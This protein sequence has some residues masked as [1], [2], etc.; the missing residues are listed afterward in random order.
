[1]PDWSRRHTVVAAFEAD[2][3][4]IACATA[5]IGDQ[6]QCV[7][8][9]PLR[10]VIRRADRLVDI[11]RVGNADPAIRLVVAPGC[12]PFIGRTPDKRD[13]TPRNHAASMFWELAIGVADQMAEEHREQILKLVATAEDAC[14][15]KGRAR[16]MAFEGL[17]KADVMCR[18]QIGA[19]RLHPGMPLDIEAARGQLLEAQ[20]RAIDVRQ[21]AAV[22]EHDGA[23]FL[24]PPRDRNDRVGRAEIDADRN[25]IGHGFHGCTP[26][27]VQ[28]L[29]INED[30]RDE[31]RPCAS[32]P[33][34]YRAAYQCRDSG[35][36]LSLN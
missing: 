21:F 28:R 10:V 22:A 17:N 3:R 33:R 1:M 30:G 24:A 27:P 20:H 16:D 2:Q 25:T 26:I 9:E 6:D 31:P 14:L 32:S 7:G 29:G 8:F 12:E 4:K 18:V 19:D 34:L 36:C 35:R 11:G 13:R 5:K 15:V 23:R